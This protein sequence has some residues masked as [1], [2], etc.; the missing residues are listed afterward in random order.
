[1]LAL[2]SQSNPSLFLLDL[3]CFSLL[4]DTFTPLMCRLLAA[5]LALDVLSFYFI[6]AAAVGLCFSLLL[7]L[8]TS[9]SPK[10][11][12][13]DHKQEECENI[14]LHAVARLYYILLIDLDIKRVSKHR[15][16]FFVG[17]F[18]KS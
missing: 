7:L 4:G 13:E 9:Q 14:S 15:R 18:S 3:T 12:N 6:F 11:T 1:M 5:L 8:L 17:C 2:V 10:S 16:V